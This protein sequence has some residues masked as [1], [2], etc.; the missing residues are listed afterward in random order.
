[1]SE[2][3]LTRYLYAKDEV[4]LSLITAVLQ[5]REIDECYYWG[6]E[7]YYSGFDVFK[8]LWKMYYDF[9]FENNPGLEPHIREKEKL[10][11]RN[12]GAHYVASVISNLVSSSSVSSDTVFIMRQY[13]E[14]VARGSSAERGFVARGRPPRWCS[15][16]DTKYR[17]LLMSIY[18]GGHRTIALHAHRLLEGEGANRVA[19]ADLFAVLLRYFASARHTTCLDYETCTKSYAKIAERRCAS[20]TVYHWFIALI[21]NLMAW[22]GG[23]AEGFRIRIYDKPTLD[24]IRDD[25]EAVET[26]GARWTL[27]YKRE[28]GTVRALG[29]FALARDG[30]GGDLREEALGRWERY[31]WGTPCW[32][33]RLVAFRGELVGDRI[34]FE[35]DDWLEE[36]YEAYGYEPDEQTAVTQHQSVGPIGGAWY[37]S[38]FNDGGADALPCISFNEGVLFVY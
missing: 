30:L 23:D 25:E 38:V 34:E 7:L 32:R 33:E 17:P 13:V 16:Y 26:F 12:G 31:I 36:F 15:D 14:R 24:K 20:V 10:W 1:M 3:L 27:P 19:A 5:K 22:R 29:G 9:Y 35:N 4:E 8:L 18:K 2:Y 6:Y 37:E 21:V 28:F 11:R